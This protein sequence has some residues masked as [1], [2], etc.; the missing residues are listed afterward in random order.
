M[1]TETFR[2][3]LLRS[4]ILVAIIAGML[5]LFLP[6][7]VVSPEG[8]LSHLP[9]QHPVAKVCTFLLGIIAFELIAWYGLRRIGDDPTRAGSLG[10]LR[11]LIAFFETSLPSMAIFGMGF[12]EGRPVQALLI[13]PV[14]LYF[15]FV[16]LTAL[17]LDP[18]LCVFSGLVAFLEYDLLA[19]ALVPRMAAAGADPT[20]LGF[21]QHH[22]RASLLF[23][24][25]LVAAFVA[26]Q[27]RR[28]ITRSFQ[29]VQE[30][31][32]VIGLF[33]QHVSPA[34]VNK[35]LQ[36]R[37]D[38]VS[39]V[40]HVCIMF[41]DIRDFTTFCEKRSP[42]QVVEYLNRLF[43]FMIEEVNEHQGVINKF[44]GDGFMAVFGAPLSDGRD[45]AHAVDA[46]LAILQRLQRELQAGGLPTTRVGLGLHCGPVVTGNI[47]SAL[48][49]EY[50]VIGDVVNLA[51]RI[52][53][54]NKQ[55]DSCLLISQDVWNAVPEDGRPALPEPTV[56]GEVQ[57]K[58]RAQPVKVLK[59]A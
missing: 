47:G 26:E 25:G 53:S 36:Q 37:A 8:F 24:A 11:V 29:V 59:L 42:E 46:A 6:A 41:L 17:S 20:M 49:K 14:L 13:P 12:I 2:S 51:S 34:I 50:T 35:L 10:R 5:V 28:Q 52:E 7:A 38:P 48:R 40:R 23:F 55:Y 33:G 22:G 57:V 19:Q 56:L 16:M 1:L 30:R 3:E 15:H 54:L 58:G 39:E 43:S 31:N 27:I 44:L 4:K 18:R 32:R 9:R 21:G 45:S